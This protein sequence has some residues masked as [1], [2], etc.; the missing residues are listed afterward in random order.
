M[1]AL[2]INFKDANI[3]MSD[4]EVFRDIDY[5]VCDWH[6]C[7]CDYNCYNDDDCTQDTY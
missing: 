3:E 1:K 5:C 4:S 2:L 7:D 6:G